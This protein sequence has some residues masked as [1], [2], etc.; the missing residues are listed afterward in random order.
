MKK[1]SDIMKK[2]ILS[3]NFTNKELVIYGVLAPI[4]LFAIMALIVSCGIIYY[5]FRNRNASVFERTAM[6]LI[7]GGALGNMIDRVVHGY[8][9]DFLNFYIFGYDYP[10][11]N[12]ADSFL[13][14]GVAMLVIETIFSKEK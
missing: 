6:I 9:V 8:V 10:V 11:F 4:V 5:L 14:V 2:D 1:F 3:E 7:C 12:V 13:V